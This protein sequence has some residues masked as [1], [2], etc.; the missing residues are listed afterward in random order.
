MKEQL[1]KHLRNLSLTEQVKVILECVPTLEGKLQD[2]C[3]LGECSPADALL[4]VLKFMSLL[5]NGYILTPSIRVDDAWHQFILH[6]VIYH[7]YCTKCYDKY[8][9]HTPS[10][11]TLGNDRQF[12]QTIALYREKYGQP[13]AWFWGLH[14]QVSISGDCSACE[15]N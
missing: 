7:E 15:L 4:E 5:G 11:D 9:H 1:P 2:Y 13:P 3:D 10:N 12:E 6:T 8:L 14:W